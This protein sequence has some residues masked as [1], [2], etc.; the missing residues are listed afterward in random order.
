[1]IFKFLNEIIIN[2]IVNFIFLYNICRQGAIAAM[3]LGLE[4]SIWSLVKVRTGGSGFLGITQLTFGIFGVAVSISYHLSIMTTIVLVRKNNEVVL[5]GD[6]QVSMGNT[7]VKSTASKIRKI[8][9]RD[10][11]Y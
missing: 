8:E 1:V 5:A 10:V 2:L 9:K 7:V 11:V 6:G 3:A 4:P